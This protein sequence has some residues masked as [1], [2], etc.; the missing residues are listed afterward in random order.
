MFDDKT[1]FCRLALA[2]ILSGL[3]GVE[4]ET[5]GR[6]AG[7]KTHVLVCVGSCLI[8]MTS[9]YMFDLYKNLTDVDP[10]RIAAGVVTGIGFLGAGTIIRF[11]ASIKGL[12][13]AATIWVMA[14]IGLAVGCG[15]YNAAVIATVLILGSLFFLKVLETKLETTKKRR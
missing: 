2:I 15:F 8:M 4:R 13:T 5:R 12:T 10:S 11:G 9:M 14:G 1:I 3:V 6:A 7:L